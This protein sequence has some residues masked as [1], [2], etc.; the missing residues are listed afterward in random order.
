MKRSFLLIGLALGTSFFMSPTELKSQS[1]LNLNFSLANFTNWQAYR[2]SWYPTDVMNQ[3]T[4]TVGWHEVLDIQQLLLT[5]NQYDEMCSKILKV[6]DGF[7]Y[8]A[9]LGNTGTNAEQEALEYTLRVDSNNSL[10]ILHF[11]FVLQNP[12]HSIN[13]QP[14]F[15]MTLKDSLGR[16]LGLPCSDINFPA[17]SG[18]PSLACDV[19]GSSGFVARNWTTVGFS[20]EA[21]MGRTIK[22]YY[23]TKDCSQ[24]AHFGYAYLVA[25]CRP[26]RIELQ[27]CSGQR[28][29][30]MTAPIGFTYYRW[31]RSKGQPTNYKEGNATV[32]RQIVCDDP[33][34]GEIFT[35]TMTSELGASCNANVKCEIKRTQID[36]N[37]YYGVKGDFGVCPNCV[38]LPCNN[39]KNWYDTC[40]RTAT[41]V[42]YTRV[43]NST[44]ASILWE[45]IDPADR[46]GKGV[47]W[48][49]PDSLF[50]HTFPDP[51]TPTT[52]R[53]RLTS[54]AENECQ[55]TSQSRPDQLI[56]IF[57]SPKVKID[58]KDQ[59]CEKDTS[60]LK[61]NVI[62]AT[63]VN[64]T[65]TDGNGNLLGTGD[66][67]RIWTPGTYILTS[68]DN[69]GCYARDTLVV[70]PLRPVFNSLD[71]WDVSCYGTATGSFIHGPIVNGAQPFK[72]FQWVMGSDTINGNPDNGTYRNLPAGIYRYYAIDAE[73]CPM[74]GEIEIKQYDSLKVSGVEYQTT[75]NKNNGR[76]KISATGGLPPYAYKIETQGGT[77]VSSSDTAWNLSP[78]T[79]TITV[80]DAII[81]S[82]VVK[83][84]T[85]YALTLTTYPKPTTC[86]TS[87]TISVTPKP[88][89]YIDVTKV[90]METCDDKD[91]SI[92][93][94]VL[95][96]R[97]PIK[98]YIWNAV[99]TNDNNYISGIEGDR[100]YT[101]AIEDANGCL[102]DTTIYVPSYP[103]IYADVEKT[104]EVCGREDGS[105]ILTVNDRPS[106]GG[107]VSND[108]VYKW[109]NL[110]DT[111]P[112]L[113]GIKAGTYTVEINDGICYW[114]TTIVIEHIPGPIAD[115]ESNS[116]NV[117][118]NTIF[119]LSDISQGTVRTW[120]WDM[121][122]ENTQTG[123]IVYYT[124]GL[125][126][127]YLIFLEVID[128]N[129][130]VDT[131]SKIIHIYE[132][133]NV[134]IPNMF[135]PNGDGIN[136]TWKPKMSEYSKEGYQMSI[137]DR[138]GQRVFHTTNTDDTWDGTV[139]GKLVAPNTVYSYRIIVRDFTGQEYE[140]VGR[141]TVLQ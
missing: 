51:D 130:C 70:T 135:T 140:F 71:I 32:A 50:T 133:L 100:N 128:E 85:P 98:H 36:A 127:D 1:C 112:E 89:P 77:Q 6:P 56:T 68:L 124:Y 21:L 108:V 103:P 37:F 121:G 35:C 54:V 95:D 16:P 104:P 99:D 49:S 93:I 75:C 13:E 39:F 52:Y 43:Y 27:F 42:D 63:F 115:F 12:G 19:T 139:N 5:N 101:V 73:D 9:K 31:T 3:C 102:A 82:T 94:K 78:G 41:F 106:I 87:D 86:T 24:T 61:I 59:I 125:S 69:A 18:D 83:T 120:N 53:V 76:L 46:S 60:W 118:S 65:W 113:I 10:L 25:E 80:T 23:E 45:I 11:A 84:N 67:L 22:I 14:R 72:L 123:R 33:I 110:A 79:Y 4:P 48:S 119:T 62:R 138:W 81:T 66:S 132:E 47:L 107:E 111:T 15:T 17:V 131:I 126:G 34:D 58:G 109:D 8:S 30:R 96:A 74:Y 137:F 2:G 105:I 55:D 129:G 64:H 116:Y 44:K 40:N 114:D 141:I 122:D 38:C 91:G 117:A 134:F 29:A 28:A 90:S 26:M 97:L 136:D 88:V 92:I 20:L 7:R 57:P